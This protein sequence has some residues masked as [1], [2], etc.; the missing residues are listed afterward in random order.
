M[1]KVFLFGAFNAL[2]NAYFQQTH[3]YLGKMLSENLLGDK[4][5]NLGTSMQKYINISNLD[6]ES[7]WADKIKRNPLFNWSKNLH[8]IDLTK[9]MCLSDEVSSVDIES[10]CDN[11][12]VITQL[13]NITNDFKYNGDYLDSTHKNEILKFLLHF[14]QDFN[15]PM[16]T[17]GDWRGGNDLKLVVYMNNRKLNTNLHTLWDSIIPEYFLRT[18]RLNTNSY[19]NS[20]YRNLGNILDEEFLSIYDYKTYL[21]KKLNEVFGIACYKT[22]QFYNQSQFHS[23]DFEKYYEEHIVKW[24]FNNWLEMII[25]T[26]YFILL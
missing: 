24:L 1:L 13:L 4:F 9:A 25:K 5:Q 22:G 23:V 20:N 17:F 14:L 12:C 16:H 11:S 19:L 21:V 15:Q 8:Y 3:M 18:H 10:T 2:V 7:V 6:K 26:L